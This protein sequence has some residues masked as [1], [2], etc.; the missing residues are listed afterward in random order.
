MSQ[1]TMQAAR[2]GA[3]GAKKT[4]DER[5]PARA[6]AFVDLVHALANANDFIYRF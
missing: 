6:S 3:P 5:E 2:L 4:V 1:T